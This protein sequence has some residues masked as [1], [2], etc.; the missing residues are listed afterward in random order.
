M[1]LLARIAFTTLLLAALA[2]SLRAEFLVVG[3]RESTAE[4]IWRWVLAFAGVLVLVTLNSSRNK[5][6]EGN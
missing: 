2:P 4:N 3:I 1:K 5:G 6:D